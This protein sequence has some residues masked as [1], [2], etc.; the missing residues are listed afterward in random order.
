MH[1]WWKVNTSIP[2]RTNEC[3]RTFYRKSACEPVRSLFFLS[4][5]PH[6]KSWR[7]SVMSCPCWRSRAAVWA[8]RYSQKCCFF[9]SL[10]FWLYIGPTM[11]GSKAKTRL[12]PLWNV[13]RHQ[14]KWKPR[15]HVQELCTCNRWTCKL[16]WWKLSPS[17]SP[18][19]SF[20]AFRHFLGCL[21]REKLKKVAVAIGGN[22]QGTLIG[23]W[24]SIQWHQ[25]YWPLCVLLQK[26]NK[27]T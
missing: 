22:S 10:L 2:S 19:H 23:C 26:Q 13:K 17:S 9:C 16:I 11:M 27:T 21:W 4:H 6:R 7:W 15:L 5:T 25:L 24:W 14:T 8:V 3:G 1:K 12:S 18:F 20:S